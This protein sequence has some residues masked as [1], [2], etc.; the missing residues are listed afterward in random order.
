M[1]GETSWTE[2]ATQ[3]CACVAVCQY[4]ISILYHSLPQVMEESEVVWFSVHAIVTEIR[5]RNMK[6]S[7]HQ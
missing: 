2:C 4:S 5:E 7:M 6:P 3:V 1:T